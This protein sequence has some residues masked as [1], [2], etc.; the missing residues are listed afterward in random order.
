LTPMKLLTLQAEGK[1]PGPVSRRALQWQLK[2]IQGKSRPQY[3]YHYH[4]PGVAL[5][6]SDSSYDY[7]LGMN[8]SLNETVADIDTASNGC[9]DPL[10][11]K[12]DRQRNVWTACEEIGPSGSTNFG[13]EQE[14]SRYGTLEQSY[15][16]N[17]SGL[18]GSDYAFCWA[19]SFDGGW[20][21][22]SHIFA[23]LSDGL[24]ESGGSFYNLGPGFYWWSANDPSG[25]ATFIPASSYCSPICYVYYM[26]T[27]GS[28]NIWFDFYG[29]NGE[30]SGYGLAEVTK[31]TTSPS[32][33]V[34]LP[35]GTYLYAG[36]VY[37]SGHGTVLNVTDQDTR[38][39]YQ[40]HLPVTPSSTP[41]NTLGPTA[42]NL[43]SLGEP[44]SGGFNIT[45]S[46]LTFGDVYGWL[47]AGII[48]AN[49]WTVA[50]N[51]NCYAGCDG[52]AYTPSDK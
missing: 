40:Y 48:R 31:P 11:V 29:I 51:A 25:S 36:G 20:D 16:Y 33:N 13:G 8:E 43:E 44:V 38:E 14:Y 2:Q 32:V 49:K 50:P 52:A 22:Q 45:E 28:G 26:D 19:I 9:Y 27:D 41:F 21:N 3:H 17:A 5:W 10:T 42:T 7:L 4:N 12:V 37:V 47:D 18:C 23:E 1:L 24:Y 15:G 6:A 35:P 39:T 30:E 34:I 46:A